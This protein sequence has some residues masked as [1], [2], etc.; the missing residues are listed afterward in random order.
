[1]TTD[2]D[3]SVDFYTKLFG[4]TIKDV[5]MG[6]GA[7]YKMIYVGEDGLGGFVGLD[8]NE[9]VPSHWC[10][11]V[12]VD[13][14][15]AAVNR[16]DAGGGKTVVPPTEIPNIGKFAM[17]A[18]P[19]GAVIAAYQSAS[20]DLG[21]EPE[22]HSPVNHFIWEEMLAKDPAAAAAFYGE[23]FGWTT[24]EMDMGEM[25][26][27]RIQ[28]RGEIPEA[29]IMAMPPDAGGPPMWLSYVHVEDVDASTAK[30]KEL[31][32]KNFVEPMS[33]PNVG[34]MS[35]NA[36]PTGTMIALYRPE[37]AT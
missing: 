26:I 31:G 5:D 36:D 17:I 12:A 35:V 3:A 2:I 23:L 6:S 9:N 20:G 33:I 19:Q 4:W 11:Y 34:R 32:G 13:D 29:G 25:G 27:Y 24:Q 37:S 28:N 16:S 1:M 8:P 22:G 30:L 10:A 15:D 18:D 7:P 14:I 21:P